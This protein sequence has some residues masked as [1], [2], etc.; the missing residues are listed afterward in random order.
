MTH[1]QSCLSHVFVICVKCSFVCSLWNR[2]CPEGSI[3]SSKSSQKWDWPFQRAL[4]QPHSSTKP[5]FWTF[6]LKIV[7]IVLFIFGLEHTV[8]IYSNND[9][10]YIFIWTQHTTFPLCDDPSKMLPSPDML[11]TPLNK[12]NI[13]LLFWTK[14]N[15]SDICT[16]SSVLQPFLFFIRMGLVFPGG[17]R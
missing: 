9:L 7:W 14:K 15:L 3:F 5:G 13:R 4:T 8:L 6:M 17:L 16:C 2:C 11:K 12:V 10:K 1:N